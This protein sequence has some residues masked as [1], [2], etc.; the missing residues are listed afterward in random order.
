MTIHDEKS[1]AVVVPSPKLYAWQKYYAHPIEWQYDLEGHLNPDDWGERKDYVF[2]PRAVRAIGAALF[3]GFPRDGVISLPLFEGVISEVRRAA[4][5]GRLAL[6]YL[7][8]EY[9]RPI[10]RGLWQSGDDDGSEWTAV[11]LECKTRHRSSFG[12]AY[13]RDRYWV[14]VEKQ[15][16]EAFIRSLTGEAAQTSGACAFD[17]SKEDYR[18][19]PAEIGERHTD[20]APPPAILTEDEGEVPES[21]LLAHTNKV[22]KE[23][24][25]DPR[26]PMKKEALVAELRERWRGPKELGQADASRMATIIRGSEAKKGKARKG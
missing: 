13:H 5:A 10:D 21:D 11:F 24:R 7:I 20:A 26:N 16:L 6:V 22:A 15:S 18:Y 23:L 17:L 14:Y 25:V 9:V 1:T 2:L 19:G 12:T 8:G 4:A 3:T